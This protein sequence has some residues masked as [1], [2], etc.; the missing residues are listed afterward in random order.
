MVPSGGALFSGLLKSVQ[1]SVPHLI[2]VGAK[3]RNALSIELIE[4]ASSIFD[5]GDETDILENFEMLRDCWARNGHDTRKFINGDRAIGQLLEDGHARGV[6]ER[7][8]TG[9]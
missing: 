6:G 8:D 7:V 5:I 9:L 2:E 4:P 3:A 1:C